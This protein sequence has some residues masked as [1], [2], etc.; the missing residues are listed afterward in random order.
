M[1]ENTEFTLGRDCEVILIPS[2][3]KFT[4]P[5]GTQGVITQ[6]LGGSY[7][8][9]TSYGL[10]RIAEKDLDALGVVKPETKAQP[11]TAAAKTN[12]AVSEEDVWNQLRQC[13]D[14]EIPV[15]IVDLGLVYDCRL[16]KKDEGETKVEVKMTLTLR[17][18]GWVRQSRTMPKVKFFQSTA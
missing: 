12:G 17:V 2:G 3:Q 8:I 4:I 1:H 18:A 13:F 5:A 6:A 9:A 14:P 11:K 15:N 7:T 10:S 16:I